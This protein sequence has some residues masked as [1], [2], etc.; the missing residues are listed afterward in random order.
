V[1]AT[2]LVLAT[3]AW[4]QVPGRRRLPHRCPGALA[5]GRTS[6][7]ERAAGRLLAWRCAAG[8]RGDPRRSRPPGRRTGL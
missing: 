5:A 6:G 3:L 2:G 7:P 1:R 4:H 8:G